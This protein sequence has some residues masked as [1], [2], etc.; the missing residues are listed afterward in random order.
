MVSKSGP[1]HVAVQGI[2]FRKGLMG[3]NCIHF[4]AVDHRNLIAK[5]K[6]GQSGRANK[7]CFACKCTA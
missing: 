2:V 7:S 1:Q 3:S 4:A 6:S 5:G